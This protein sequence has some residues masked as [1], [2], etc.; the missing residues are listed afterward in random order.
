VSGFK[1]DGADAVGGGLDSAELVQG[2]RDAGGDL[3]GI[4]E[5]GDKDLGAEFVGERGEGGFIAPSEDEL[6][7]ASSEFARKS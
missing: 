6:G 1:E 2:R 4:C 5:V 7:S 3:V